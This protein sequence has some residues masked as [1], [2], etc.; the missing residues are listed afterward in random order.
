MSP[1]P[2]ISF[3]WQAAG[4]LEIICLPESR[5]SSTDEEWS[6]NPQDYVGPATNLHSTVFTT[7]DI[8]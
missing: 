8:K 3:E 2:Y 1:Q 6:R 4:C 7:S 5:D